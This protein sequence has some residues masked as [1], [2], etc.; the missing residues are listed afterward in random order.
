[1]GSPKQL[2]AVRGQA[3]LEGVAAALAPHVER[4]VL[5]GD[6]VVPQ[7]LARL[8]RLVDSPA[9]RGP[10]AGLLAAFAC[11]P[12]A[13]WIAAA[14]DLPRVSAAAVAWLLT[15]R[16]PGRVAV[17]PRLSAARVEPLLAL[18]EPA[19]AS[20]LAALAGAGTMTLQ[21]LAGRPGIWTPTP[22]AEL[23]DA[24]RNANLPADL[25]GL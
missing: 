21:G 25:A 3:L 15:Q 7:S 14:C 6:G 12:Q 5:L 13:A 4:L 2:L 24:W 18:Y 19:S 16:A 23:H 10:L 22:P 11:A 8:E 9:A 1:M 20:L 17:L